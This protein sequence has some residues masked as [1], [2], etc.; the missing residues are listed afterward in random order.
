MRPVAFTDARIVDPA[1][2]FDGPGTLL[3]QGDLIR[4]RL[5]PSDA[6]PAEAE[7]RDCRGLTLMPGLVDTRAFSGEPGGEH[8]E[9]LASLSRAAAAGGVTTVIVMPD[10][11]PVMDE[12]AL[13]SFVLQRASSEARV[14]IVPSAALTAG[15]G[16]ERLAELGLMVDAGAAW[17]SQGRRPIA[18]T[19][20]LKRAMLYARDFDLVVD[21]PPLDPYLSNGVVNAGT[22]ASWLGLPGL[23]EEAETIPLLRDLELARATRSRLN[24]ACASLA[25]SFD[26]LR[27][28]KG[29]G[30][31]VSASASIHSLTL[32]ETDIGAYRTFFRLDPPLRS[33]EERQATVAALADGTIDFVCSSHDPQNADTKR[34][35]FEDAASGAIGVETLLAALLRLH[36]SGDVPLGRLIETVTSA[37]ATRLGLDVGTLRPGAP[38]DLLLV[39]LDEPWVVREDEIVSLSKNTCFE[40][41]RMMG[42]VRETWVAGQCVHSA[43][44]REPGAE[45]PIRG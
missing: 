16:G 10:T 31:D 19:G 45:R 28:A 32:N 36:H 22:W 9:T 20:L 30:V 27:R 40:N 25:R 18:D 6:I 11:N 29:S 35:P 14:R 13:I 3:V 21:L 43:T 12:A 1:S 34:L 8:R 23:P 26:H 4:G 33:E 41:A 39:D 2:S 42:R 24:V 44:D 15:L 5:T 38:A 37:P 7:I 17:A